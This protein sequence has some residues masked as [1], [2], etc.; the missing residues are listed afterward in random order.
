MS[1]APLEGLKVLE[2]ARIL[3]GP[4]AGQTL[5][6]LGATV[7]KV[8]S[9][10]GDDT[11]SWGPPFIERGADNSAAYY[12]A[13]NRGKR[14]IA[15]DFKDN[16]DL[17][18]AKALAA[19]ADVVIENFKVGGLARFGLD[20]PSLAKANP[21]IVYASI[22]GFGQTGPYA[23]KPGYDYMIQAMAGIMSVTGDPHGEP[24]KVGVA[25][26]DLFTGLYAV[27]G[28]QAALAERDRSGVGQHVDLSLFESATAMLANQAMNC[29]ASGTSPTRLGNAHPN[30]VPY[31]VFQVRDG[32][33][34]IAAGN[35]GQYRRMCELLE[36][37]DLSSD[38]R[39]ATNGSRVEHRDALVS[40]LQKTLMAWKR[41]EL[42]H[43][44]EKAT[45]PAAP[46]NTVE[47]VL[48]DPQIAARG[49]LI[50]PEDTQG[51]RTPITFSRSSLALDKAAPKHHEGGDAI[52]RSGWNEG[53]SQPD[54]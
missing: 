54:G 52:R 4:W 27:V 51:L 37:T 35:D 18:F 17:A 26:A 32:S 7:I 39:F 23:H 34:V 30:I 53:E 8:E 46:I 50:E 16:D 12:Y 28:I 3:A 49:M 44:L 19:E 33:L 41:D 45:V 15:L 29:L 14:S 36:R 13:C 6:D 20:Y 38:P 9:P 1:T 40:E 31:Q 21:R 5:A 25:V 43:A 10:Q 42:L 22:S 11:R 47:D 24:Q 48:S 2:L